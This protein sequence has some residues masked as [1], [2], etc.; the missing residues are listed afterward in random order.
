M[1]HSTELIKKHTLNSDSTIDK[2]HLFMDL[3]AGGEQKKLLELEY[4]QLGLKV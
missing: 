1:Y 3:C 4:G 2:I